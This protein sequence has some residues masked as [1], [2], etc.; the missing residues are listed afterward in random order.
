ML[1]A[2]INR[3]DGGAGPA[4]STN[5]GYQV[6]IAVRQHGAAIADP[7]GNIILRVVHR[8][9]NSHIGRRP[10]YGIPGIGA[11]IVSQ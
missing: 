8:L 3:A 6:G 2:L 1:V 11:G 10:S 7:G 9:K 4:A 5:V